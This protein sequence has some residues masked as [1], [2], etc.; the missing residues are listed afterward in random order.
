MGG[1]KAESV[2][3]DLTNISLKDLPNYSFEICEFAGCQDI[4]ISNTGYTGSGGFELYFNKSYANIIW[5]SIFKTDNLVE[6]IGLA[7]RDTL[8]L[9]M[10]FCLYGNDIDELTS[11]IEAGLS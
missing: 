11:P 7:A 8:R 1:P 9:E 4:I 5:N 3:Q 10:G 2:L 6:P